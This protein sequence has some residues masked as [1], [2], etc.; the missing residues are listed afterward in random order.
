MAEGTRGFA[1]IV[2]T[3]TDAIKAEL[4]AV[5]AFKGKFEAVKVITWAFNNYPTVKE[6]F[7][8][9]PVFEAEI[10]DLFADEGIQAL[11]AISQ[12]LTDEQKAKSRLYKVV[13]F[14]AVG[15][16]NTLDVIELGKQQLA[17]GA[18]IFA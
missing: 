7:D 13:Q 12:N 17:L 6:A 11:E 1:E 10:K 5:E 15:Y 4:G 8:D 18:A 16:K 2:D 9:W 14:A 3:V